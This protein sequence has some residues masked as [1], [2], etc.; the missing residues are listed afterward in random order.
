MGNWFA[1]RL[2][3]PVVARYQPGQP[4]PP[5]GYV[6]QQQPVLPQQQQ[7]QPQQQVAFDPRTIQINNAQELLALKDYWQ[8]TAEEKANTALCPKCGG[9]LQMYTGM[10]AP[11]IMNRDGVTCHPMERCHYCGFNGHFEQ[12]GQ[13]A[14]DSGIPLRVI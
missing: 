10:N 14:T 3:P 6:G 5:Q 1:E 12:L 2:G 8:G 13:Q 7:Y 9:P 4:W 11:K